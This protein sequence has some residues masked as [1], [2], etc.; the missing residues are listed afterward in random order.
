MFYGF[1][2]AAVMLIDQ[3]NIAEDRSTVETI[4]SL[5]L[6]KDLEASLVVD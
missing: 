2:I 3:S 1:I 4:L 6:L 5:F